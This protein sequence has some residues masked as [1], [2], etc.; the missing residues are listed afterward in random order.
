MTDLAALGLSVRSDGVIVASDRLER[1]KGA[2]DGAA[3][4]ADRVGK[5]SDV[6]GVSLRRLAGIAGTVAGGIAAMFSARAVIAGISDFEG[7]MSRVAAITRATDGE[8][9]QLRQTAMD[10]G[11][12]TEFSAG[13][14]ADALGFLGMAGF[15]AA[16]SIAAIPAVLD[17]ATASGM[18][19]A[20]AADT[21]SNIMSG[22]GVAAQD[23]AQVADLL[24]A[25][26]SRANTD[27]SQLGEAMKFVGPVA[28]SL[29]ISMSDTAAAIG[30]LSDAGIQ[31]GMA[32][33][34][35]RQVLSSLVSPTKGARDAIAGLGLQVSDLDP[36]T[37]SLT[38]IIDTLAASGLD[39]ADAMAIAGQRGGP[40]LLALVSQRDGLASL[41]DTLRDVEGEADR[42]ASTMRDNLRGDIQGLSSAVSG[43][44]LAMGDAGLTTVLRSVVQ[45]MTE[46]ARFLADNMVPGLE[47]LAVITL[48]LTATRIPA[49]VTA[50]ATKTTGMTAASVAAGVLTGAL[51][52]LGA[53][54]AIAG[55]PWGVL[56]ALVAGAASYML[57][58]RDTTEA[59]TPIMNDA[60]DAVS[61]INDV[62]ATA[63]ES[64]LPAAAR[65][66]LNLTNE[67]IKLARSAY[68]AAE[69]ELAR[70]RAAAQY[71]QTELGLQQA[72][73]PTGQFTQA[74][75]VLGAAMARLTKASADLRTEQANLTDRINSGQLA[76]SD[77]A[78]AMAENSQ[79]T[80]DLTLN[81][82]GLSDS[83]GELSGGRG[84]SARSAAEAVDDLSGAMEQASAASFDLNQS[85][86][87]VFTDALT[88]AKNLNDGI[89]DLLSSMASLFLNQAFT[90]LFSSIMPS[91]NFGGFR[92]EGGPVASGRSYVVG[93]RGPELF[94]PGVSG[95][96]TPNHAMGGGTIVQVINNTGAPVREERSR[97]P[98]GREIIRTI[99]GEEIGSG[100]MDKPMG[101]FG[102]SPAK[103]RR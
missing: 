19:L 71:A 49:F 72:F 52:T 83:L 56:A 87:G 40:A 98:D 74:E 10:L 45:G 82:D 16:E 39:A 73:S 1:F 70:A 20:Q 47:A 9:R 50:L 3:Q 6:L 95:S 41:S 53:A 37:K 93:E 4:G 48:A 34:S 15:S 68:A 91:F 88:G 67:N 51:R 62:L 29:K 65:A 5:R 13:Q 79:R 96:I 22:F 76:L 60:R 25:A 66:T 8:L 101:R 44:I 23:A 35:L 33:T 86:A 30:T 81:V 2:S 59:S 99:I 43:L 75:Q 17:L 63:S 54:V 38:E 36:R 100:R 11:I 31:G 103:V 89:K 78:A 57:L 46:V 90:Q 28:S 97:G 7:S 58:F 14:A 18:G 61:R 94:T 77:A 55:G 85:L 32:G 12:S 80:V 27:V 84:G 24:A 26:S 102:L 92:A 64:A 42:M 69:A 21:A